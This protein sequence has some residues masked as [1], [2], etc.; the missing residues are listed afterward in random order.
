MSRVGT[1]KMTAEQFLQLG[2]DPV[3]VR[4]ELV[5]G[6]VAV[7][8]SPIPD[9]AYAV[10]KLGSLLDYHASERGLGQVFP[11]VDTVFGRHDVRRPDLVFF[12]RSRLRLVGEKAMLG[13][14]DLCVEVVS[15]GSRAVDRQH[16]FRQ[17]AAAKVKHYWIVDPSEKTFEAFELYRGK[18]RTAAIGQ[19]NETVAAPPFGD[20]KIPLRLLWRPRATK[21]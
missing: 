8:P 10:L 3:G 5:D 17:Y 21:P 20:L 9:H 1:I 16:K 2:E 6:E 13:A 14:P 12:R 19:G 11:D 15:P 7:S 18:Y 4:L